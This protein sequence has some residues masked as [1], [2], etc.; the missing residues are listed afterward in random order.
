MTVT[1]L[2]IKGIQN[3]VRDLEALRVL[4]GEAADALE[5]LL[6]LCADRLT[7]EGKGDVESLMAELHL[8]S[9]RPAS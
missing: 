3:L 2:R 8:F 1:E 5:L 6:D 7:E 4:A 9:R